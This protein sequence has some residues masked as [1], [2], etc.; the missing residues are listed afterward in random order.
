[1]KENKIEFCGLL[2]FLLKLGLCK[3]QIILKYIISISDSDKGKQADLWKYCASVIMT[4]SNTGF[5]EEKSY[6]LF[7]FNPLCMMDM[8]LMKIAL[9]RLAKQRLSRTCKNGLSRVRVSL[10]TFSWDIS[11]IKLTTSQPASQPTTETTKQQDNKTKEKRWDNEFLIKH[12][13]KSLIIR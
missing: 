8:D 2:N 1:M 10:S 7:W 6:W 11:D 12:L 3:F 4:T 9:T 5:Y 13:I